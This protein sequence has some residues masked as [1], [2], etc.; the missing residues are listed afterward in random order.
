MYADIPAGTVGKPYPG[1]QLQIR[2]LDTMEVLGPNQRGEIVARG[3]YIFQGY[4][5]NPEVTSFTYIVHKTY[6]ITVLDNLAE[7]EECLHRRLV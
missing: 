5:K 4:Y 1:G 3:D 7:Y 6:L 2:D